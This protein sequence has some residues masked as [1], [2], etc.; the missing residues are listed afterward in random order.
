MNETT[1]RRLSLIE[2]QDSVRLCTGCELH[3]VSTAPVPVSSPVPAKFVVVGQSPGRIED[4]RGE[5]FIG[6]AGRL[7]RRYM[8][9]YGLNPDEAAYLNVISCFPPGHEVKDEYAKACRGNLE[10]QIMATCCDIL[11]LCGGVALR[12]M[13]PHAEL[14]WAKGSFFQVHGLKMMPM[15]HPSFIL[16]SKNALPDFEHC[17]FMFNQVLNKGFPAE[18]MRNAHCIYCGSVGLVKDTPACNIH[19]SYWRLDRQWNLPEQETLL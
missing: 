7:L 15:F 14:K 10:N 16:K 17:L 1:R 9:K 4:H 6:P 8:R 12:A 5:P 11:L 19:Q 3:K 2:V 13:L 18:W